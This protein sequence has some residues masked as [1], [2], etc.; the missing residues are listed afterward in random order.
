MLKYDRSKH[1]WQVRLLD[2]EDK[3]I[4]SIKTQNL[5]LIDNK[6]PVDYNDDEGVQCA[7]Q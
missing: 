6:E 4:K 7:Q 3:N 5:K 2:D 1:R